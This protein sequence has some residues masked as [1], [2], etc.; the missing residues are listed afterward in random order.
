MAHSNL[1][2]SHIF[3]RRLEYLP[4]TF[5]LL[6]FSFFMLFLLGA[7]VVD[8]QQDSEPADNGATE[9][10]SETFPASF[11]LIPVGIKLGDRTA[12]PGTLV[13]GSENG[14]QAIDFSNWAIAYNDVLKA[15]QF[16]ATPL[17]DGTIELRSPAAVIRL[18][19]SLLD[20]DPQLGLVFTVTQIRDLLQIPVEFDISE[21]AIVLTPEWLRA[22]GS[23]GLTGRY[24][25]P[26]RTIVLEGLP[27]IEAPNL[28]FSAIGQE[29]RVTGGGDRPTEYEGDLVGIG[30]FFGG[31]WYSKIDQRDLTDPRSWQLEE[32]QYLRQTP[33]T[34]YVIGDQ[35]TFWPEGSG[36]YTGVSIVRRF[37]FQPPTEFTNASNGF[38]PQQRLNS[39]RLERDI[40]GRAEPG[41]LVQLV[42]K[43]GNLIVGEQLVDQSGIY[44]FE[45]I[46]SA[47]TNKGRGGI[48]GNRYELRL[49]PNG[50]LSA[51]PEIRAAEFSSLPGQ[52]SK[53]TS[54]LLL[55]AGFER[56]RQA[57]T[58]FGSLSD[59]LQGGFAYRWGAT[60]NLT[61]GT[62]L[63]YD[64]QLKG[65]GEFF[66]QPGRLPLRITGAAT[67]NSDEQQ[68]DLRYDLNVRFNPGQRFDFEFDKDELSERIRTRWDVSDNFR[69][70]FNSNSS[71]QIAQ[72]TWRLF[73]GF[74]TRV[75]WSFNNKALEGGFD[76]S[77]AL[78][79]L[80][81]RNSVTFSADQSP[82]WRLFSR[83]QNLTLDHRLRDRQIATE[84]EYFFRNP[85]ALVDTG[86]SVFARYQSSPNEDNE[87]RTNELLVAGWRYEMNSTVGD[88]LSDWIVDLGYGV[89]TQGAGWQIAV[90]TNQLLGLNLTAR[91]Q[92]ISLTG[93]ESSFSLLIGSDAILSPNFSLK[94]SRFERLR[95]EGG[96]VV[97]PFIDANRNGVQDETETAY[98]Q[99]IEAETADF[100]FLINEQPINRFSEYEP[101][102]RRRGIFVRLPPDTYRFDVDPAGLPLGW[103][104]TQSAFAVEVSAGSYTPIYVPLTRAYIVAG[105]V[106]NAQGKPLG[107]VRV[108]AV[109]Q[110]N[111]QER[112]LS[113]TNGA[114]IYY[115]ESVG[116]GVYDLFIDGKPAKPGQL[117]IEIDAEEF[118]ELDLRL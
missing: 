113:V 88:R 114:G 83:Y 84:V 32:F 116:T 46:P 12:N 67:F 54:A 52:L 99:G 63:F 34:D 59:D 35:R 20:T 48:A 87:A 100:L 29:I 62:G 65:L 117:R 112:S 43:N 115:L 28:S 64:G 75:G 51:F 104:T 37:G 93:N 22:S 3:P 60:D 15:L 19:P 36:R 103:Q 39:D 14:I 50:Q 69:L 108:E 25:L 5:R 58:F 9:T 76:L 11:D 106:V 70:A 96:I 53:G 73:P 4:L 101:D 111:P 71:D 105:T 89:G 44:R 23:L 72:A 74:S 26:E 81:I 92:D 85:E 91:Y 18:D 118:T 49:Y 94:P 90:T 24:S 27:R 38:N 79:D 86:H 57:D 80:L 55:S 40:R 98:L 7:E 13:R 42:N 45:N 66:F 107:G 68:S 95:T 56:L 17:A 6:L 2:K 10:T 16:T 61:L 109:N 110:N 47:S 78:G 97:I 21:Y 30:T 102:L 8:A 31:S 82:D 41:T 77:G 1:K 33:S